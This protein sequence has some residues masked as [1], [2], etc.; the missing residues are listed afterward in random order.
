M[1]RK[2][3]VAWLFSENAREE[4]KREKEENATEFTKIYKIYHVHW[5]QDRQRF[6]CIER[7]SCERT[8]HVVWTT[9]VVSAHCPSHIQ[10]N[11]VTDGWMQP[12]A[13]ATACHPHSLLIHMTQH[14][15]TV[16]KHNQSKCPPGNIIML[17]S[18]T[19]HWELWI[20]Y[21]ARKPVVGCWLFQLLLAHAQES[22]TSSSAQETYTSDM[23]FVHKF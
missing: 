3:T 19:K 16:M 2:C 15:Y 7:K 5:L 20:A 13:D 9:G 11:A 21:K 8:G 18:Y 6:Q 12:C 1:N 14:S 4:E 17:I 10:H 22:Y 23:H